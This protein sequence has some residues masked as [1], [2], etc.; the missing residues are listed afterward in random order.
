MSALVEMVFKESALVAELFAE[1]VFGFFVVFV[2]MLEQSGPPACSIT[3][4][5]PH[6]LSNACADDFRSL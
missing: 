1:V 5:E 2:I 6:A 4:I 3:I